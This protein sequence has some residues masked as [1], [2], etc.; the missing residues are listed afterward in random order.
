MRER[1]EAEY[2]QPFSQQ[3]LLVGWR[4]DGSPASHELDAVS[5]DRRLVAGIKSSSGK[6]SG[7][8]RPSGKIAAAYKELYFLSLVD[9]DRRILVLTDRG[10]YRIMMSESD[11]KLVSGLELMLIELPP[12]LK[13]QVQAVHKAV[14]QEMS[15]E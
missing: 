14:S 13:E 10:F 2:G 15:G 4:A 3:F 8:R 1:L 9:A 11:G 6:T 5:A 7:G 12:K